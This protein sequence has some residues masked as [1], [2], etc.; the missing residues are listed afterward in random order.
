MMAMPGTSKVAVSLKDQNVVV[1]GIHVWDTKENF[2]TWLPDRGKEFPGIVFLRD[3]TGKE[4]AKG[5]AKKLYSVSGIPTQ[6]VI[7]AK[8]IIQASFV[9]AEDTTKPLE[10]AIKKAQQLSN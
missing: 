6:Y 10:D 3:P 5:I 4:S 9:G 7:D 2:D 8:G 1:L